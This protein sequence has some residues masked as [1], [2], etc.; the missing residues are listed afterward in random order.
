MKRLSSAILFNLATIIGVLSIAVN[1][2]I[3][4]KCFGQPISARADIAGPAMVTLF[5]LPIISICLYA[6]AIDRARTEGGLERL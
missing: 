2:V 4:L 5:F 6:G 3:Y 1:V